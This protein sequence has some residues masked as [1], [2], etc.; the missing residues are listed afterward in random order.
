[1]EEHQV[2]ELVKSL[3]EK[4]KL[5]KQKEVAFSDQLEEFQSQK[6]ELSAVVEELVEKN[7][8]LT[9][10]LER[11]KQRNSELDNILYRASHDLKTPVSSIYGLIEI[12]KSGPLNVDQY[13]AVGHLHQQTQQMEMR[14]SSLNNL[15]TAFFTE[16]NLQSCSLKA[17]AY[18]TWGD[19][20]LGEQSLLVTC[21]DETITTDAGMLSIALKCLFQNSIT[22]RDN[23][24]TGFVKLSWVRKTNAIEI[25]VSDNGEGIDPSIENHIFEMFYRGSE[26]SRG[27]GLGLYVVKT[28][29]ERLNGSVQYIPGQPETTFK[30]VLP[31]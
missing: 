28:I 7:S 27:F 26:K 30:L 5:L 15:S 16:P 25:E 13:V 17:L 6:E 20:N 9:R 2:T 19:C 31:A 22:Y 11:L 3:D 18:K 1:M 4:E 8:Y 10:T 14:L 29:S 12:L 21:E 23:K 24:K